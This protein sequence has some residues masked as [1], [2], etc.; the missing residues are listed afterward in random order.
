MNSGRLVF[1]TNVLVSALLRPGGLAG[2][3]LLDGTIGRTL[4]ASRDTAGELARVV[5]RPKFDRY[6]TIDERVAFIQGYLSSVVWVSV[7]TRLNLCRDPRDDRFL[8]L[9]VD[10]RA[11]AIVSGDADLLV[12]AGHFP[13]PILPPAAFLDWRGAAG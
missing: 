2:K 10:G 8:E 3:A 7:T 12:L 9:A 4:L 6:L 11:D 1:D 5:L 13:V